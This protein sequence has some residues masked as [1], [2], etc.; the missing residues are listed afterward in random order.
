MHQKGL[1]HSIGFLLG[2]TYRKL[3][4]FFSARI[5]EFGLTPEQWAVLYRV[6]EKDGLIQKE[7]AD[8]AGKDKPTTTRILDSLE[9]KGF[10][11]KRAS[12]HDR[13]SFQVYITEQGRATADAIE[14]IEYSTMVEIAQVL[15]TEEY[16]QM[17]S[18]LK[19]LNE[20]AKG[21]I[22]QEKE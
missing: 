14:P 1:D 3:T 16:E 7:I 4:N 21:L 11:T 20:H 2:A 22:D 9:A 15:S 6:R 10:V 19:K 18:L 8:R 13:R 12:E 5:K 17:T